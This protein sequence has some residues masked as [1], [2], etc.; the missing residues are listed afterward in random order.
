ML[1]AKKPTIKTLLFLVLLNAA[2]SVTFRWNYSELPETRLAWLGPLAGL[3]FWTLVPLAGGLL[4]RSTAKSVALCLA[5]GLIAVGLAVIFT[6]FL[7]AWFASH[8]ANEEAV[9]AAAWILD[10]IFIFGYPIDALLISLGVTFLHPPYSD[11]LPV[12]VCF[13]AIL[14]ATGWLLARTCKRVDITRA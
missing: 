12:Y 4:F 8:A 14:A 6:A 10:G 11:Q 2:L 7:D 3:L 13:L 5:V 1:L 9:M